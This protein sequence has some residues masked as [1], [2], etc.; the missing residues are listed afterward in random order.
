ML[1][2]SGGCDPGHMHG[3]MVK[4]Q[5]CLIAPA[6]LMIGM[7]NTQRHIDGPLS[8]CALLPVHACLPRSICS[9]HFVFKAFLREIPIVHDHDAFSSVTNITKHITRKGGAPYLPS[10]LLFISTRHAIRPAGALIK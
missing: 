2:I 8:F 3:C 6:G 1:F 10:F 4:F 5:V 9:C 7:H